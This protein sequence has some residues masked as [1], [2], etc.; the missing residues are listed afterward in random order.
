[1]QHG[2]DSKHFGAGN[3]SISRMRAALFRVDARFAVIARL[4]RAIEHRQRV[5]DC[6]VKPGND[7]NRGS[8]QSEKWW[9]EMK[10]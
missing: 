7:I 4:D 3:H 1:V 8:G 10:C 5:L 2:I 6:P 9:S